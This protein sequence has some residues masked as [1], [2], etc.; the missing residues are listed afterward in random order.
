MRKR[1]RTNVA[2]SSDAKTAKNRLPWKESNKSSAEALA[3]LLNDGL[4]VRHRV[5]KV[6]GKN[7]TVTIE[8]YNNHCSFLN[9]QNV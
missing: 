3:E 1:F 8:E 4:P 5:I 7:M 9:N 6:F 2:A